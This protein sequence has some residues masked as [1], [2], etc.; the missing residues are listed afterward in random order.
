MG[1]DFMRIGALT[2]DDYL[3]AT[4]DDLAI[5]D[6]EIDEALAF[7]ADDYTE[8]SDE[9]QDDV[10]AG[11]ACVDTSEL[12]SPDTAPDDP[13]AFIGISARGQR[14]QSYHDA[15]DDHAAACFALDFPDGAD[16]LLDHVEVPNLE[17]SQ[18]FH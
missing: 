5:E 7:L 8:P 10:F 12:P 4:A 1:Y 6:A 15:Y 14:D 16:D 11:I 13:S 2:D 18:D 17:L 3:L 9:T